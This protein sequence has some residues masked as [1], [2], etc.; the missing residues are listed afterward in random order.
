MLLW[1]M[2]EIGEEQHI[3][4]NRVNGRDIAL[5]KDREREKFGERERETVE[6]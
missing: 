1:R 6:E 2:G 5:K 4:I 3:E